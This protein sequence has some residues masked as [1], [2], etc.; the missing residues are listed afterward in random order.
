MYRLIREQKT[1]VSRIQSISTDMQ[2]CPNIGLSIHLSPYSQL[3][4]GHGSKILSRESGFGLQ[5]QFQV[6]VSRSSDLC[7]TATP[8][9]IPSLQD[10]EQCCLTS[11]PSDQTLEWFA[12]SETIQVRN[13][14]MS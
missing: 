14:S 7:A 9:L 12:F 6:P 11:S 5:F 2:A 3:T 1:D 8:S 10:M 4:H 13:L